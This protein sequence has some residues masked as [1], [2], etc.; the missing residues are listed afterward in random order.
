MRAAYFRGHGVIEVIDVPQPRPKAG[1]LLI[2]VAANGVCGS[3]HKILDSSFELIPGHEVV[4]TV[5]ETGPDCRT[6][7]GTRIAAYIP[8]HCGECAFCR[9]GEGNLCPHKKGL[10][11]WSTSGGYAEYMIVPDRNALRLDER[12]TFDEGV[13]LL[14]TIGT[15]GHGLRLSRCWEAESL[16]IIGAG[17]IGIGAL[18]VARAFGVPNIYVSEPSPYRRAQAVELGAIPIDPT[19]EQ[20]DERIRDSF[21][22]GVD[23][24]FE[25]VGSLPTIWQSFDLVRPG[26]QVNLV[27]EY[28]GRVELERP[29]GSWMLNDIHAIR[30][31]Y[32]TIPEFYENQQMIIDGRL[33]AAP[34]V[35]HRFALEDIAEAYRLFRSG[36]S[37]KVTVI[38]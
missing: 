28:W 11:G 4:G 5:V 34:L 37:L 21:A 26:G 23:I 36:N 25:A 22:D 32:F 18:A 16:L 20:V 3:D 31:F 8:I 9:R 30:S 35:S 12:V 15:S 10:L 29:K 14:D 33:R 24:V 1:E 2:R 27:G 38:P 13:A 6:E 17:P 19:T 7:I